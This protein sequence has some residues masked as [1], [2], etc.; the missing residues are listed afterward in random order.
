MEKIE[1]KGCGYV[2]KQFGINVLSAEDFINIVAVAT[3]LRRKPRR[4]ASLTPHHRFN[5]FS[6][7]QWFTI[8]HK[9]SVSRFRFDCL[10]K[11]KASPNAVY[12]NKHETA[13]ACSVNHLT[14]SRVPTLFGDFS[15]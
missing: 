14:Y 11:L 4:A 6:N 12:T 1:I 9:K 5:D 3:D 2:Q 10:F 15:V 8:F 7:V 13:H